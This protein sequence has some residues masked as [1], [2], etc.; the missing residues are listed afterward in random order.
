[1]G[2]RVDCTSNKET[3][4][5][6]RKPPPEARTASIQVEGLQ[7]SHTEPTNSDELLAAAPLMQNR[8]NVGRNHQPQT[9]T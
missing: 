7:Q 1:M 3:L 8:S 6:L 5:D 4:L 9:M 2:R